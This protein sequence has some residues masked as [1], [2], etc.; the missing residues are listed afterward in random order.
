MSSTPEDLITATEARKLLGVSTYKLKEIL[1]A[2]DLKTYENR[3]DRR[4]KLV[5]RAEVERYKAS[6][7]RE[8]A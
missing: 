1:K 7:V 8:A 5:S 2:G 3:L 4:V 6:S